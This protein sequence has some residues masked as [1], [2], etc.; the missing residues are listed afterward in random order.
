MS[1][2]LSHDPK[3]ISQT[4]RWLVVSKPAGW[5]TIPGRLQRRGPE[6][7]A[8]RPVL[9]EWAEAK[10]G[11]KLW[12]V[13]RIDLETSG[14]VLFART[15][16][17]HRQVNQWFEKHEV[18]KTYEFLAAGNPSAPIFRVTE[19][20]EGKPSVTQFEVKERFGSAFLGRATPL[21]GRRHQIRIHLSKKGHP[22]LGDAQ[23]GGAQTISGPLEGVKLEIARVALHAAKLEL[24]GG[25]RFEAS[26]PEDFNAW[27]EKLK[28]SRK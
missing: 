8:Q 4:D 6:N 3:V 17:G 14:I 11:G 10:N 28:E 2:D 1:P 7:G 15:A 20:I 27:V 18:R 19:P 25:E 22:I 12:V 9:L 26:W 21:S 23:Y 13:H 24:P 5:L 16:E